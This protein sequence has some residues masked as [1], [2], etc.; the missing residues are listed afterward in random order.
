MKTNKFTTPLSFF[1]T[2]LFVALSLPSRAAAADR[3]PNLGMKR[4]QDISIEQTSDGRR[5]LKFTTIIVN[6]GLGPFEL[7]GQ[8]ATTLNPDMDV[9]QRIYNDTGGYRDITTSAVMYYAGDGH[10]HWHVRDLET[11]ELIRLDNGVKVGTGVKHGFCFFDNV[12][13]DL[14]LPGAPQSPFYINCGSHDPSALQVVMGLSVGWGDRYS[15]SL[16]TQYI[17]ITGLGAGRYRLR[18]T[19]D[20]NNWFLESNETDNSTWADMHL[21]GKGSS[22]RII[23]YGPGY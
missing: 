10:N 5:L 8:R 2:L 17:D 1:T 18:A 9:K 15:A 11:Y 14:T 13:N 12:Q 6:V 3:L 22:I 21:K 20:A 23:G 19:A 16:A 4:L 7:H